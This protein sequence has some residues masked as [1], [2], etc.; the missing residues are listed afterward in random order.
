MSKTPK[1]TGPSPSQARILLALKTYSDLSVYV[2]DRLA[3]WTGPGYDW[4]TSM[5]Y[6][7]L[8]AQFGTPR[9]AS[10][11]K[12]IE[13]GWLEPLPGWNTSTLNLTD[14][15]RII[16]DGL[17]FEDLARKQP[18]HTEA[19]ILN[20]LAEAYPLPRWI[21]IRH[22]IMSTGAARYVYE[23]GRFDP[24][25]LGGE[26]DA[27]AMAAWPSD[28]YLRIAFEVKVSKADFK[29]E[30]DNPRKRQGAEYFANEC[31]FAAP[32]GVIETFDLP[33]RWGLIEIAEGRLSTI[34]KATRLNDPADLTMGFI[35][36]MCRN[37][38]EFRE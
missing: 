14:E 28:K 8:K 33:K 20:G 12:C 24:I 11:L 5:K 3:K 7:K 2:T 32:P 1:T 35:A 38:M 17:G 37:L 25:N 31:Y 19:E 13:A 34:K 27:F 6:S 29:K 10:V 30:I 26:L 21:F 9:R 4:A 15:G 18:K 22:L 23:E 36:S 16:A